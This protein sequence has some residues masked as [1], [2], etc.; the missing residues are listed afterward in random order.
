MRIAPFLLLA[1][2]LVAGCATAPR[3]KLPVLSSGLTGGIWDT[4]TG[5]QITADELYARLAKHRFVVVG[6]EHDNPFDHHIEAKVLRGVAARVDQPALGMEMFQ[7]PFQAAL[8]AYVAGD[9][10][11]QQMLE[12][13]EYKT[14]WGM[15]TAFYSPLWRLARA[16]HFP[17]VALNARKELS[18]KV[19]RGGLASLSAA[20]RADVPELDLSNKAQRAYVRQAFGEHGKQM[21]KQ[22]FE[23]FYTAQ[24]LWDETMANT[25][26]RF[27]QAHP[28]VD[29]MVIVAGAAH[30]DKRFGIP[31]RIER[32]T[33]ADV[34]TVMP[35]DL[36]EKERPSV[37]ELGASADYVWAGRLDE[38]GSPHKLD[39]GGDSD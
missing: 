21:T 35:V 5:E 36:F 29:T 27:V 4:R 1:A 13:T 23:N 37:E 16:Q 18:H 34:I 14:R 12:R 17:I 26:V 11:E 15:N 31:P 25:A 28:D 19:A 2:A 24:V 8:D 32:R 39:A 22:R 6:E 30:A 38:S 3:P 7:R 10:D 33:R 20:E 9:I